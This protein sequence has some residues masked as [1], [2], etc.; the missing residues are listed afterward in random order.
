MWKKNLS[1]MT[2]DEKIK[3]LVFAR[4]SLWQYF[5]STM[6]WS[7]TSVRAVWCNHLTTLKFI[8]ENPLRFKPLSMI[9]TNSTN[10]SPYLHKNETTKDII[11]QRNSRLYDCVYKI[12]EPW[13]GLD[14]DQT[15]KESVNSILF[16]FSFCVNIFIPFTVY[17]VLSPFFLVFCEHALKAFKA[18]SLTG[19]FPTDVGQERTLEL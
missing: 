19:P 15:V 13:R 18:T 11:P 14:V 17:N 8:Y 16:P 5:W 3:T 12:G 4:L 9:K 10:N 7:Y 2:V 6:L 1:T